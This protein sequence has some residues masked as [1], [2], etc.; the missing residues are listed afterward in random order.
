MKW[1]F[2]IATIAGTEVRIHATFFLLLLFVAMQSMGN[3]HGLS[4]AIEGV[5]LVLAMFTCVLLHEFGH[6]LSARLYGIHTPDITLLPIGGVARLERMPRKPAHE[7]VVAICGPLVNVAIAG[8]IA[9]FLGVSARF[10]PEFKFGDGAQFWAQL[11]QW[12]MMMVMFNMVPAFPMDGGRVLRAFLAMMMDYGKATR[13]AATIGQGIAMLVFIGMLLSGSFNPFMMLIAIFIFIAA[14]QEAA[15]VTQQEATRDL[16]VRDAMLTD[17][18]ALRSTDVLRDAVDHLLAGAQH[19]FPMLDDRGSM[20][21]ML[22]R[23]SLISALAEHGPG[24]PAERVIDRCDDVLAPAQPLAEALER[25]TASPCPAL[26][27]VDPLSGRLI[28]LLTA[29]NIAEVLMVRA[30]LARRP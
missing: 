21:G 26:P 12:N 15:M 7:L 18:R 14:G 29:E 20:V 22:S 17:F 27:V 8:A 6:V 24:C 16:L 4:G 28:G 5:V 30:A 10:D 9:F 1:S 25:L 19:D 13:L 11:V 23:T 2:R 3:G